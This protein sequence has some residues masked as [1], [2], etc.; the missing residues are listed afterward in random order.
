MVEKFAT[1]GKAQFVGYSVD[2]VSGFARSVADTIV[3]LG[4]EKERVVLDCGVTDGSVKIPLVVLSID[5]KTAELGLWLEKPISAD[6]N[7]LDYNSRYVESLKQ[8]GWNIERVYAH[9]W[10]DNNKY[11]KENIKNVISKYVNV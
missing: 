9:D 7:Y 5:Y 6:K 1:D 8:R 2:E 4:V 10:F 3:A 11:E